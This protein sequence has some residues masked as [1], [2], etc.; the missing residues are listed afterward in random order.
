MKEN[1]K[2]NDL[3]N[4]M[5]KSPL[6]IVIWILI[7]IIIL[8]L[9]ITTGI[10]AMR[11]GNFLPNDVDV[12]FLVPKKPAFQ[13]LD[14]EKIWD[15]ETEI[16][17]FKAE[18]Y[19]DESV[20]T[21]RSW[22]GESVI[23][24]GTENDYIFYLQNTGNVAVDYQMEIDFSLR[25]DG[26]QK[27][28]ADFPVSVRIH[29]AGGEYLIGDENTWVSVSDVAQIEN[30]G[31]LGVNSYE[32]YMLEWQWLFEGGNDELDTMLGS[33]A[34]EKSITLS[35]D[36]NTHAQQSD[37]AEAVGGMTDNDGEEK[38]IGGTI[39]WLPFLL[40]ILLIVLLV[41]ALILALRKRRKEEPKENIKA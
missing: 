10:L 31:T 15:T 18:Y 33:A 27:E 22:D 35:L 39:R 3:K 28:I 23:A 8:L 4:K 40:L 2:S 24:P 41:I 19:N 37:D 6:N 16:D 1:D 21:V 5:R 26:E 36:V 25:V 17:V 7:I 34:A 12:I 30:A 9:C 32:S 20:L 29:K 11:I 13:A 14:E 38:P